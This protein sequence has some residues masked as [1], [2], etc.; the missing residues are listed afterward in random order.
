MTGSAYRL[1]TKLHIQDPF[2]TRGFTCMMSRNH[3]QLGFACESVHRARGAQQAAS[4]GSAGL[5]RRS[6]GIGTGSRVA[7]VG[8]PPTGALLPIRS[9]FQFAPCFSSAPCLLHLDEGA[10]ARAPAAPTCGFFFCL[11]LSPPSVPAGRH[12]RGPITFCRVGRAWLIMITWSTCPIL[13]VVVAMSSGGDSESEAPRQPL[14]GQ[15]QPKGVVPGSRSLRAWSA[16]RNQTR[17]LMVAE[18]RRSLPA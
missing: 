8:R 5:N 14:P 15:P 9:C 11:V 10:T 4:S 18:D 13:C 6:W 12:S 16:L 17:S 3:G 1:S 7:P 2:P